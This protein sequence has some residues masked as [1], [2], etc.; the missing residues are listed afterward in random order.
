[1]PSIKLKEPP[2]LTVDFGEVTQG[3]DCPM[4]DLRSDIVRQQPQNRLKGTEKCQN[5]EHH[6]INDRPALSIQ[7]KS[8]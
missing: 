5:I 4:L 6:N 2:P 7:K 1:M 8:A 3:P